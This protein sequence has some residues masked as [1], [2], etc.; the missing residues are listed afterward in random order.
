V[1][2]V[3]DRTGRIVWYWE[4]KVPT[5]PLPPRPAH[6]QRMNG[7]FLVFDGVDN[8]FTERDLL[9]QIK[10]TWKNP[11]TANDHLDSHD[12]YDLG[13][14]HALMIG[15]EYRDVDL[16][17]LFP[18]AGVGQRDDNTIDEV[19]QNGNVAFHWSTFDHIGLDEVV[20]DPSGWTKLDPKDVEIAHMNTLEV[21]DDSN[22][23]ATMRGTSSVIKIDRKTGK[24]L[25][26]MGGKKSDFTFVDDPMGGFS[27]PH[28]TRR[29]RGTKEMLLVDNGNG[30]KPPVTRACRYAVDETGK[31]AKLVWSYTHDPPLFSPF[32]GNT[33]MLPNGHMVVSYGRLGTVTEIDPATKQVIWE[34]STKY[35]AL[36]RAIWVPTLYP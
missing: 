26:R 15:W 4:P 19:D 10:H 11:K 14:G 23:V 2:V 34:M 18:G 1:D 24:I 25:W 31:T 12:F 3:I 30:H 29:I 8:A 27:L 6:F 22:I 35:F 21:D 33:R 5:G 7:N 9:G 32:A 13:N 28:D 36:Y 16:S 20:D 17:T